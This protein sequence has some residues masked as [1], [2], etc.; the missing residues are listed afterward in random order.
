MSR[1]IAAVMPPG[2]LAPWIELDGD[3]VR[4]AGRDLTPEPGGQLTVIAMGKASSGMVRGALDA[5]PGRVDA[6]VVA[7]GA[8]APPDLALPPG[9]RWCVGSHPTPSAGSLEAAD[10]IHD[11][12][13][14]LGPADRVLVLLSGGAS[15]LAARPADGISLADK[16]EVHRMLVGCGAPIAEIN[17]VRKHLSSTKGGRLAVTGEAGEICVLAI[18]D[19][20]GDS[21]E[22]IGSG[23]FAADST[24]FADAERVLAERGLW[25]RLPSS[26]RGHI[27]ALFVFLPLRAII[28]AADAEDAFVRVAVTGLGLLIGLQAFVNIAVTAQLLPVTGVTLP[29]ISYGG[30]SMVATGIAM[31]LMLALTR[32]RPR[33]LSLDLDPD[34]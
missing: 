21:L 18:S 11:A 29:F 27:V 23:P 33:A 19:V 17:C 26:V 25:E 8:A 1:G 2:C 3:R 30:S 28:R 22:T 6:L 14:H 34:R 32:R 10:A 24:T 9:A 4:V 16:A 5:L 13:R 15:A 7:A 12:M 31:G 20:V